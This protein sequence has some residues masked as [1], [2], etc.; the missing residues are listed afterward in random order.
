MR[1]YGFA[2]DKPE[3]GEVL[4]VQLSFL[5]FFCFPYGLNFYSLMTFLAF[6]TLAVC[7]LVTIADFNG[8]CEFLA[9]TDSMNNDTSLYDQMGCDHLLLEGTFLCGALTTIF[10][11]L[12]L[13]SSVMNRSRDLSDPAS[14]PATFYIQWMLH[15]ALLP[16]NLVAS[17]AFDL[18]QKPT[19][20]TIDS[21]YALS[22]ISS[23]FIV[24][25]TVFG[26]YEMNWRHVMFSATVLG[27]YIL[28]IGL[29]SVAG[30][31]VYPMLK[32]RET[33]ASETMGL[34]ALGVFL[35]FVFLVIQKYKIYITF[36]SLWRPRPESSFGAT[37]AAVND[38]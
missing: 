4:N 6:F 19:R 12:N 33:A 17:A 3:T 22:I 25:W 26:V 38:A 28:L 31:D 36:S 23:L 20:G 10:F 14:I 27:T 1:A 35:H 15:A 16:C 37:S 8:R 13:L 2:M 5:R 21:Y 9:K 11:F 24:M 18:W 34:L 7:T 32:G 30:S 29:L